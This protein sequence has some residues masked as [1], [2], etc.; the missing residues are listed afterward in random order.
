M[1]SVVTVPIRFFLRPGCPPL[2]T[3]S[4]TQAGGVD[5]E[6]GVVF[7]TF[8]ART[9]TGL[10]SPGFSIT[11]N[12]TWYDLGR[13]FVMMPALRTWL[14]PVMETRSPTA[15]FLGEPNIFFL[16]DDQRE[17]IFGTWQRQRRRQLYKFEFLDFEFAL[18]ISC[19]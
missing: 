12:L 18:L 2:V 17:D 8:Q 9:Q 3:L 14:P 19:M 7:L 10:F 4:G 1:S 6:G 5:V 11:S 13:T 15:T 16:C